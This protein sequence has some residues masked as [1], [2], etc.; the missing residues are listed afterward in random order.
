MVVW[1]CLASRQN[2]IKRTPAPAGRKGDAREGGV[3]RC[4]QNVIKRHVH[5]RAEREWAEGG[6]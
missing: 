3:H 1:L 6:R 2:V 5:R 4:P